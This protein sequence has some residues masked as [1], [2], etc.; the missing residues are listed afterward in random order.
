MP[1]NRRKNQ[2]KS[3]NKAEKRARKH[4]QRQ[5]SNTVT[6][7][8][9]IASD[10]GKEFHATMVPDETPEACLRGGEAKLPDEPAARL[11]NPSTINAH[12]EGDQDVTLLDIS[13]AKISEEHN[14]LFEEVPTVESRGINIFKRAPAPDHLE[15]EETKPDATSQ[16]S[17]EEVIADNPDTRLSNID[18]QTLAFAG[19][20]VKQVVLEATH[21]FFQRCI[22]ESQQQ[23]LWDH[24]FGRGKSDTT[25]KEFIP[26]LDGTLDLKNGVRS[27]SALIGNCVDILSQDALVMD[28]NSLKLSLSRAVTLCDALNDEKRE[29]ALEKAAHELDWL[30]LGLDCKTMDLYRDANQKLNRINTDYPVII[31]EGGARV[32]E[33]SDKRHLDERDILEAINSAFEKHRKSFRVHFIEA[34]QRMLAA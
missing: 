18:G 32:E 31:G 21:G 13:P 3:K 4:H 7:N 16:R 25:A 23:K 5:A 12:D 24:A 2:A 29:R 15:V 11:F 6:R 17:L 28:R 8:Q 30:M 27:T 22:P 1:R 10:Q 26:M 19:Q 14:P 9:D 33:S 20:A 34:L